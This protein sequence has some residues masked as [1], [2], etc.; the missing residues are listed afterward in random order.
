MTSGGPGLGTGVNSSLIPLV[1]LVRGSVLFKILKYHSSPVS[2]LV[3]AWAEGPVLL[4]RP[5]EPSMA[6]SVELPTL[7][8]YSEV[9]RTFSPLGL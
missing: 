2:P 5:K 8:L 3:F 4:Q 9:L 6:P 7:Y 1:P